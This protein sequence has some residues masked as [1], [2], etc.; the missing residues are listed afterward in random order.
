MTGSSVMYNDLI[1]VEDREFWEYL[2]KKDFKRL[3][4]LLNE[5]MGEGHFLNDSDE[6]D[7]DKEPAQQKE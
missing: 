4:K 5:K 3:D 7:S 2:Q 1:S 6:D